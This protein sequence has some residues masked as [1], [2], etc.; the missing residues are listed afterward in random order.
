MAKSC[1]ENLK[2][3]IM[4][5]SKPQKKKKRHLPHFWLVGGLQYAQAGE[6]HDEPP[7]PPT[8]AVGFERATSCCTAHQSIT[9]APW[10]LSRGLLLILQV[11]SRILG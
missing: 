5:N 7:K 9:S 6:S 11:E 10:Q 4:A 1:L 3:Y 2:K 8:K